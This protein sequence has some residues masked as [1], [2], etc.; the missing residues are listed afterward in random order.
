MPK[1]FYPKDPNSRGSSD[2]KLEKNHL[3]IFLVYLYFFTGIG[4]LLL[5][6]LSVMYGLGEMIYE[7]FKAIHN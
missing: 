3:E 2:Y 4:L 7:I 1:K 6:S 5:L